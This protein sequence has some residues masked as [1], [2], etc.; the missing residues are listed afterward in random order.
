VSDP[1]KIGFAAAV[2]EAASEA[3]APKNPG[4]VEAVRKQALLPERDLERALGADRNAFRLLRHLLTT[5]LLSRRDGIRIWAEG[6]GH[7]GIDI[8]DTLVDRSVLLGLPRQFAEAHQIMLVYKLGNR[9]TA[10]VADP[11]NRALL[12]EAERL[13]RT[14]L[15]IVT[16]L[17]D[18]LAEAIRL[19]YPADEDL[20]QLESQAQ[21][22]V[23][24]R[25]DSEKSLRE[26]AQASE[27]VQLVDT[28]LGLAIKEHASD[29]H[30]EPRET[31]VQVRFRID[32]GL[33]DRVTLSSEIFQRVISRMK[34]MAGMNITERRMPQDGRIT[35]ALPTGPVDF[36]ASTVPTRYGEKMVLRSLA[37]GGASS[38]PDLDKLDFD[39]DNLAALRRLVESDS[40]I[41]LA[42]GPTGSGKTTAL[43][44]MLKAVDGT[45]LNIVTAEEPIEYVLPRATQVAVNRP[46]GLG[47]A[48][49]LRAFMR[50][51]PDVILL[52][53]IR[54]Q[55]TGQVAT[56]AA[57]TGHLVLAS[58]HA[59]SALEAMTRM[60]QLG[61]EGYML[62]PALRGV[63]SQ[64]LVRRI[65]TSCRVAYK[66]PRELLER[67]FEFEGDPDVPFYRG[68]GCKECGET[69]FRGRIG[70]PELAVPNME[71]RGLL[72]DGAPLTSIGDAARRAG[73]RP[74]IYDG[75]K[76][77]LR[78]L[79]TIE[80]VAGL[81]RD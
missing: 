77:V 35:L 8:L 30:V 71:V 44:A 55:E 58:L 20:A 41:L 19:H 14:P 54:D 80:E 70:I 65:C 50:Q 47:F 15:S 6:Y 43:F 31:Q 53:E 38:I 10:A 66:P 32:G 79:T 7:T 28:M 56:E 52:G 62:G 26:E 68:A 64:R 36:R 46:I 24:S 13:A 17:P 48:Q 11:T 12:A 78:G 34:L 23:A 9:V 69:G 63:L 4:F 33:R 74:L 40:G 51:D 73:F 16:A 2:R 75:L 25:D 59:N 60:L 5:G 39:A 81:A 45:A 42:T 27:I 72:I 61:I 3:T 18:E 57:Q 21:N 37:K 1:K 67:Y 49:I 22:R 76:K 29:V